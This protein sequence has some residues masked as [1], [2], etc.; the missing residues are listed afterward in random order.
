VQVLKK[1]K[2]RKEEEEEEEEEEAKGN[3]VPFVLLFSK[4]TARWLF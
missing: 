2:K 4:V 3:V 1:K